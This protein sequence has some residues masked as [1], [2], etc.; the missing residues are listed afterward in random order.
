VSG[1]MWFAV[2][3]DGEVGVA[4]ARMLRRCAAKVVAHGSGR[5]WLLGNWPSE[6]MTV[7]EAG[8]A[9][10]A[11]IGRF[12]ADAD[13]LI[14]RLG[15][16]RDVGAVDRVTAGFAGSFHM[17]ASIGG[18]VRVR[19]S[20]SAARRVF[21]SRVAGTTVA[22]DRADV[23]ASMIGASVDERALALRMLTPAVNY[24]FE[25]RCVWRGVVG[26]RPDDCLIMEPDGTARAVRWWN[27]PSAVLSL[28]EG[29]Q[30]VREA[31]IDAVATCT[32]DGGTVSADLSG[33]L[34]TTALC[35]LAAYGPARL[36]TACWQGVDPDNDDDEWAAR[37][38]A[39]LPN[40]E[41]VLVDRTRTPLWFA[42]LNGPGGAGEPGRPGAFRPRRDPGRRG[43]PGRRDGLEGQGGHE[44][45]DELA[46]PGES[47]WSGEPGRPGAGGRSRLGGHGE[48][49][50]PGQLAGLRC[51]TAE[52]CSWIR[53]R[54]KLVDIVRRMAGKGARLHMCGGGGDE[55][56]TPAPAHLHDLVR[57]HPWTALS[58]LRTYRRRQRASW[59]SLLRALGDRGSFSQWLADSGDRLTRLAAPAPQTPMAWQTRPRM[60]SWATPAAV[61][62]A[63]D[64]LREAAAR[65]PEPL[66]PE[67]SVHIALQHLRAGGT[68]VNQI[69]QFL[70]RFGIGYAAPYT[71]D[72]VMEAALSVR[73]RERT[74][75]SRY[76]PLLAGAMRGIVPEPILHRSAKGAYT[77]DFYAGLR[78][79]R[80][81]LLELLD[82]SM[83]S[84]LGLIDDG[85][86]RAALRLPTGV[87]EL[88]PLLPTLGCEVWLRSLPIPMRA[89][90][91]PATRGAR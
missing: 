66:S 70:A 85:R 52:P 16:V 3:P 34:D 42:G 46:G 41:H 82:G 2:V 57:D 56:F 18:R 35:F 73:L 26:L 89:P 27:P 78:R 75:P 37:V 76:K 39:A 38:A 9:R 32:A 14:S 28:E 21:H 54:A 90:P 11:M 1:E 33:G 72:A 59:W 77:A 4:A 62:T 24:P 44:R 23:L 50:G 8:S 60:P 12:T 61:W 88:D 74:S 67:R 58:R 84:R 81:D 68:A 79:H 13:T 31:L 30:A 65:D 19:G 25:D 51:A 49:R 87:A 80:G 22:A 91:M 15:R 29:A 83:L 10:L 86:A 53:D 40:T 47:G 36:V 63:A 45:R 71:D 48:P 64:L 55:L 5:P 6:Q 17:I 69:D 7:A 20:A 43:D